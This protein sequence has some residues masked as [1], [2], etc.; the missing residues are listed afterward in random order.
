M[1]LLS[2]FNL[3][4]CM[5]NIQLG[6]YILIYRERNRRYWI[7][8]CICLAFA[9]WSLFDALYISAA[10]K[11]SAWFWS[12]LAVLGW[13]MVPS[14]LLHFLIHLTN[15]P[16]L[17]HH[18]SLLVLIYLP[19][20]IFVGLHLTVGMGAVDLTLHQWGWRSIRH[21][22]V[23]FIAYIVFF[24][25]SL[26]VG[27][28]LV[29]RW[30]KQTKEYLHQKQARIILWAGIVIAGGLGTVASI[31]LPIMQLPT[32]SSIP[33]LLWGLCLGYAELRHRLVFLTPSIA[34]ERILKVMADAL[35]LIDA[36]RRIASANE[37]AVNLF[38]QSEED[39][40]KLSIDELFPDDDIF[41]EVTRPGLK[42]PK[43][44]RHQELMYR[45]HSGK[46]IPISLSAAEIRDDHE[47]LQG[48]VLI[49]R[50]ISER[51]DIEREL[52]YMATHDSLTGLPNR[53]LMQDRIRHAMLRA[54]R[55]KF[56]VALLMLDLDG[57]KQVNDTL[58]HDVGDVLL[59]QVA[60]RLLQN[61]RESDTV[62]RMGGDEFVVVMEN[63]PSREQAEVL[64]QR[65]VQS[66]QAPFELSNRELHVTASIGI[67]LYPIHG[68]NIETLMK[69]ADI[70]MYQ[71]KE[72]GRNAYRC[73][74]PSMEISSLENWT[75]REDLKLALERNELFL[76]YQ[77]VLDLRSKQITQIEAL[78]RWRHPQLGV[79]EAIK[80]IPDAEQ[81]GMIQPIG[82]WLLHSACQQCKIWL[83]HN[84]TNAAISVNISAHQL[85][86]Q[87]FP[88][89]VFRILQETDL[90]AD[91]LILEINESA[92]L[93]HIERIRQN[94]YQLHNWGIKIAIDDF[95]AGFSALQRLKH[96]PIDK[97]K[98]DRLFIQNIADDPRDAVTVAAIV[99]MAHNLNMQVIA[100]G[101]ESQAQIKAL[102]TPQDHISHYSP[103]YQIQGHLVSQPLDAQQMFLFL[104]N[105]RVT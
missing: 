74:S 69:E 37:M 30:G 45:D 34:A 81:I 57:F 78:L 50:D 18:R 66:F 68:D 9:L 67:S 21:Y 12:R 77:P 27:L 95:G 91:M 102:H 65:I 40:R 33:L 15:E 100:E 7:F 28:F 75:M 51:K 14:L 62:A 76:L 35:L 49:F 29:Y 10:T 70:A 36:Q 73:Y 61:V 20:L 94:L 24:Y 38:A 31:I 13:G 17:R 39:L 64:A 42:L 5:V 89:V 96:L 99:S 103:C 97:L 48:F 90:P 3:L 105:H 88:D 85:K 101:I 82:E 26:C 80:F 71:A 53:F 47:V 41:E 46:S 19:A 84:L 93:Q 11:E 2:I 54:N 55:H 25:A 23:G 1:K 86:H 52:R 87:T 32:M 60:T 72:Q 98:L 63:L 104:K 16:F 4:A 44:I 83:D 92:T 6:L 8:A 56:I 59:K 22:S 43:L 79:L 58:G